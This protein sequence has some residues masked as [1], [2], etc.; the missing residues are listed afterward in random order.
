MPDILYRELNGLVWSNP[1]NVSRSESLPLF[2]SMAIDAKGKVHVTWM[3]YRA[4][5]I[6]HS[7]F[8]PDPKSNAE[9]KV[10]RSGLR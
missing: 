5:E 3:D 6:H 7:H 1:V 10:N 4:G 2:P 8:S 9:L